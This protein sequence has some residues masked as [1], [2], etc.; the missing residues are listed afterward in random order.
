MLPIFWNSLLKIAKIRLTDLTISSFV[1]IFIY[2]YQYIGIPILYLQLDPYRADVVTDK[3]V[4]I[5]V[6]TYTSITIT[7]MI[8]GFIFSR[9]TLSD[10]SR[11][12]KSNGSGVLPINKLQNYLLISIIICSL[13]VLYKYVMKVGFQNLALIVAFSIESGARASARSSMGLAFDGKYHWYKLFMNDYLRF[14]F[15]ALYANYL[16]V[17]TNTTY[18]IFTLITFLF[19]VF[20]MIMGT[21]KAPLANLLISIMIINFLVKS[22]NKIVNSRVI[23]IGSLTFASLVWFYMA[24]MGHETVISSIGGIFSRAFTGQIM[25]AYLYLEY[26]PEVQDFLVGRSLPN[27]RNIFPF[28]HVELSKD[29]MAWFNPGQFKSNNIGS[30]PTIFWGEMY[31]NFGLIGIIIPP[32]FVGIVLYIFDLIILKLKKTPVTISLLVWMMFHFKELGETQ[33]SN[34]LLDLYFIG[35]ILIFIV[36]SLLSKPEYEHKL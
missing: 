29:V 9:L 3:M 27:P 7:L 34:Y 32:F 1:L 10:H 24:F 13:I 14:G 17:K 22:Q 15:Y 30:M 18:K 4:M 35:I 26:I 6:F 23:L 16:S 21:E 25:P 8:F 28:D 20:V 19:T 5:Q 2:I 11:L 33:L 31:A 12:K 36:F